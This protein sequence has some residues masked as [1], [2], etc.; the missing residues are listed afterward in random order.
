M[1]SA[2]LTSNAHLPLPLN[3]T[4]LSWISK[5]GFTKL[6]LREGH[7]VLDS[8]FTSSSATTSQYNILY[9]RSSEFSGTASDPYLDI[10]YT[11]KSENTT[12]LPST[13]QDLN[14]SYDAVG[15]ITNIIDASD[16]D[17][18]K[19]TDYVYDDLYRLTSATETDAVNNQNAIMTYT[20]DRLGN[21]VYRSD[22][23]VYL[24]DGSDYANPHAVTSIQK[25]DGTTLQYNY[26]KNGNLLSDGHT[27]YR[28]DY[29]NR[30]IESSS[31]TESAPPVE[32]STTVN[33]YPTAGDGYVYNY[34]NSW[35]TAH[36]ATAG[37]GYSSTS[38]I[39]SVR[40]NKS[41]YGTYYIYRS[42]VPFDTSFL[43][44]DAV[45]T[46][47]TLNLYPY[48]KRND[49]NDGDDFVTVVHG[50]QASPSALTKEDYD[51][52]GSVNAPIEGVDVS[53]RKDISS[54]A[55][56]A[57]LTFVLNSTGQSWLSKT[58]TTQFA[59]REGHDVVDSPFTSSSTTYS[60]YNYVYFRSSE[61]TDTTYD[62]YL[63]ITY[64]QPSPS[65]GSVVSYAYDH[66]GQRVFKRSKDKT[67]YYPSTDY[68]VTD[69]ASTIYLEGQTGL[70]ASIE[71]TGVDSHIHT[72][73]T[74]HL[75]STSVVTDERGVMIEL[76]DY[77]P[78]GTERISWSSSSD[79][80]EAESQKTYIGEYSDDES[81]LSYLNA[82]YYD[83]G[84]G[85]FL[86]Q[87][88]VYLNI[89]TDDSRVAVVLLDPQSQNSYSYARNNPIKLKDPGGECPICF[90]AAASF[91][92]ILPQIITELQ[93]LVSSP[94]MVASLSDS[95]T[96]VQSSQSGLGGQALAGVDIVSS[97]GGLAMLGSTI[98]ATR[99]FTK[100]N[101]RLNFLET[102]GKT[103]LQMNGYHAHHLMPQV[104]RKQFGDLDI[105]I[106]D[107]KYLR[108]W[109][110][111][112]AGGT[113]Q[114]YS[115]Q[116]NQEWDQYIKESIDDGTFTK[117]N[118]LNKAQE[119]DNKY[120]SHYDESK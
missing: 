75:G 3:I 85:Q 89:G 33:F 11:Q 61:Y 72:T 68:S 24:Y 112:E 98:D 52:A 79:S 10:T 31:A 69:G 57:Y 30:L 82:R 37:V 36:D 7:D 17:S 70:L 39:L 118:A 84:R 105:N 65:Q 83:P 71:N 16:V 54:V 119:L 62:P 94:A 73:H 49:D 28:W 103:V 117:E 43:P 25:N 114:K 74:D 92:S 95:I 77:H 99:A 21:I 32:Q 29:R 8:A 108:W 106:D 5:T 113:H 104:F 15:N 100:Y 34:N 14:Y 1:S 76:L 107:P 109:K 97:V 13:I 19:T 20:Y 93:F 102:T 63:E 12:T 66:T 58:G 44:D 111:T 81:G 26:D 18:A 40:T 51:Q 2:T 9:I 45:I 67:T 78:Y 48:S 80:G 35:D 42:F 47:A 115:S 91:L 22:M 90:I 96:S 110:G 38:T 56:N 64:T 41:Q 23:G 55:I 101:Y 87:D 116:Y 27:Q 46:N 4:G 59:L 60:Q 86:S 50:T 120:S 88:S 53:E 6:G